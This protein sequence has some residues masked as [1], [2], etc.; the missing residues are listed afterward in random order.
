MCS[1]DPLRGDDEGAAVLQVLSLHVLN[2]SGKLR[3]TKGRV[4]KTNGKHVKLGQHSFSQKEFK[5]AH[6]TVRDTHGL[7]LKKEAQ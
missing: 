5:L 6:H 2:G 7:N 4:L 3:K 1:Q